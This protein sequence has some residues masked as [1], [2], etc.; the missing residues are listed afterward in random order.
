MPDRSTKRP[1][2]PNQLAYQVMLESTGQAPKFEP[3]AAKPKNPAAVA[4]GRLGGLK[5]GHAR[6]AK[7]SRRK[8][9]QISAKAARA[10]WDAKTAKKG[11]WDMQFQGALIKEQ[12]VTFGVIIVKPSVLSN[13]IEANKT[14]VAFKVQIFGGYPVI[15][16]AQ[17]THGTPTYYGRKDIVNFMASVPLSSIPWKEY[18]LTLR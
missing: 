9:S 14:I 1:R 4:L 5:G 15:L 16:M 8:R 13:T 12:N 7:L 3:P 2:D 10:R 11:K 17:D 18:T 6:A